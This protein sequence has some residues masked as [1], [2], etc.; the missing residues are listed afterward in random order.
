[1][2]MMILAWD[3]PFNLNQALFLQIL[4]PNNCDLAY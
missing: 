1:M 2:D 3:C 4:I